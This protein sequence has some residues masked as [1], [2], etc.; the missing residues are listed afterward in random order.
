MRE[1]EW[2]E[3]AQSFYG[4]R[5]KALKARRWLPAEM[6]EEFL[7]ECMLLE[8]VER[9]EQANSGLYESDLDRMRI[10]TKALTS[11][12]RALGDVPE[13]VRRKIEVEQETKREDGGEREADSE[14]REAAREKSLGWEDVQYMSELMDGVCAMQWMVWLS[15]DPGK[16]KGSG[17]TIRNLANLMGVGRMTASRRLESRGPWFEQIWTK[18]VA[19]ETR[20]V[21]EE[22]ETWQRE[23][24]E[25]F[26]SI[27]SLKP[28]DENFGLWSIEGERMQSYLV[29]LGLLETEKE[30][31]EL[32]STAAA[33]GLLG[34]GG[35]YLLTHS[36]QIVGHAPG[37]VKDL[38]EDLGNV[39]TTRRRGVSWEQLVGVHGMVIRYLNWLTLLES[40]ELDTPE[41][42]V[43]A[44]SLE[45][46]EVLLAQQP[47]GLQRWGASLVQYRP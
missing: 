42:H 41:N 15:S 9:Q 38:L 40:R 17:Y 45:A 31:Q 6:E 35:R 30:A 4:Q 10:T 18:L 43:V 16:P 47:L 14:E 34:E 25:H 3:T 46:L 44:M 33:L 39:I 5:A 2:I 8:V 11:I 20:E 28:G 27:A 12:R 21:R 37:G 23:E 7:G 32:F 24:E 22:L 13:K 36:H 1:H 29:R 19:G 26:E